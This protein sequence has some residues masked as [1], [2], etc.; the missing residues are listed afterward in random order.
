MSDVALPDEARIWMQSLNWGEHHLQWHQERRWDLLPVPARNAAIARGWRRAARQEGEAGNGLDFLVMHRAMLEMLRLEWPAH[1]ARFKGWTAVP[2]D[3]DDAADPM[4]AVNV[5]QA[6]AT[7]MLAAVTLLQTNPGFFT[8]DDALGRFIETRL[9]PEPGQPRNQS[10]DTRAGLHNY[11]HQRFADATSSIDL[12]QPMVNIENERFWRLHGWIDERWSAF[13]TA[14]GLPPEDAEL[15]AAIDA[16]KAHMGGGHGGHDLAVLP[17][18]LRDPFTP[19][20]AEQFDAVTDKPVPETVE[21]LRDYLRVAVRLE[22]ATLPLYLTAMWSLKTAHPAAGILF[23]VALEEMLHMGLACNLLTAVGG[24]PDFAAAATIMQYPDYLPGIQS[25]EPFALRAFSKEQM[26]RFLEI[27][28]PVGG[29]IPDLLGAVPTFKTIGAFYEAVAEGFRTIP[30]LAYNTSRQVAGQFVGGQEITVITGQA[31][32]LAAIELICLQGEGSDVARDRPDGQ[33]AHYYA[34]N[35]V[36]REMHY[37]PHPTSGKPEL[38]PTRPLPL[39]L[40]AD[41]FPMADV[42]SGGYPDLSVAVAFDVKYTEMLVELQAAW[43][44]VDPDGHFNNAIGAMTELPGL[45]VALMAMPRDPQR[46]GPGN[47][48]PAFLYRV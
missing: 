13:R 2:T 16:A 12:G 46:Y 23:N 20:L 32:A 14:K 18:S 9:R 27:E 48:G 15:R 6:F 38:D 40:P 29:P 7:D 37:A 1:A 22:L 35:Q 33:L 41:V 25:K 24:T 30:G 43:G 42:P 21:E 26:Q 10:A 19:S 4:P 36:V 28:M 45:A 39:P 44:G 11:L 3:P 47:Y 31:A 5:P 17:R 8:T 34:F